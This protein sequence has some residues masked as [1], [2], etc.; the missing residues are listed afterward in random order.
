MAKGRRDYFTPDYDSTMKVAESRGLGYDSMYKDT[1]KLLKPKKGVNIVRALPP[2]WRDPVHYAYRMYYH[3]NIGP[4]DR[5]YLCPLPKY[6][7]T[8]PYDRCPICQTLYELG[9]SA[10]QDDKTELR[11]RLTYLMY[12]IDR[13]NEKEGVQLWSTGHKNI[14]ELAIQSIDRRNKA[15]L[16]ITHPDK[17]YDFE[18]TRVGT[19]RNDT[20]YHGFM[21]SRESTPL[22]DSDKRYNQW[23][24]YAFEHPIPDLLEFYKP[25]R[26]EEEFYGKPK[27]KDD[28]DEDDDRSARSR[29]RNVADEDEDERPLRRTRA[30][31]KDDE[32]DEEQERSTRR[33]PSRVADD[34]DD[35][36]K[37]RRRRPSDDVDE[38]EKPTRRRAKPSDDDEDERPTRSRAAARDDEDEDAKP[39]RRRRPPADE[40]DDDEPKA[41]RRPSDDGD[42]EERPARQSRARPSD[43]DE[44]T[45][46]RRG[47]SGRRT[48]LEE[49]LDDSIP[50]D[51]RRRR[52]NGA[53][54]EDPAPRRSRQRLEDD[55]EDEKPA[56][57]RRAK[58]ADDDDEEGDRHERSRSR[59]RDR[60]DRSAE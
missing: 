23:L 20:R 7:P 51:S 59:L 30:E 34:E 38:D 60:L 15:V 26:I 49:D 40:D 1:A 27:K 22:S 24:D 3:A 43:D 57:S 13:D 52:A 58:P 42:E 50:T 28:D 6:N 36:P 53:D 8:S 16:N 46:P 39:A 12:L 48:P 4:N 54:D 44:D 47:R 32:D 19:G 55:D 33:R 37:A 35:E 5:R 41:R 31:E 2:T 11:P 17:G 10:T 9:S 45:E 29:R 56:R 25:S 18:F 21:V 14:T